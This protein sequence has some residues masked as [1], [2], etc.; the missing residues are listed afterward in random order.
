MRSEITCLAPA[1]RDVTNARHDG[2]SSARQSQG[3]SEAMPNNA[4]IEY[5]P[6]PVMYMKSL[7]VIAEMYTDD[8]MQWAR[9]NCDSARPKSP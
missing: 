1:W 7:T 4:S 5:F 2:A 8:A 6:G 3:R 9:L